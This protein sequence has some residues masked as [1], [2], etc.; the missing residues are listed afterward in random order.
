MKRPLT[1]DDFR[2]VVKE[3]FKSDSVT[4]HV[5]GIIEG[6]APTQHLKIPVTVVDGEIRVDGKKDL[7][8][9]A[10]VER[11]QATGGVVVGLVSGFGLEEGCAIGSTVAHDSHHMI[12]V[13]TDDE[14]MALA[15][16]HLAEMNGGQVVIKDGEIIG[17]VSLPIAGLMSNKRAGLVAEEAATV[18]KG[19]Q[20]CGC[21]IV[22]PNMQLSLLA[23]VVIPALRISDLGLVDV[24]TFSLIP[25]IE[26]KQS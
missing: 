7:A 15:A 21:T 23:L 11:H 26:E 16:N 17:Q 14:Q 2:L 1:P 13:G 6:Q 12:V 10:L 19:F 22:N 4:A 3:N 20:T 9:I 8:K 5:I 24:E 25:L 18:L